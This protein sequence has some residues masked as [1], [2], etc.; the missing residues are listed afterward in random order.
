M[1]EESAPYGTPLSYADTPEE[2][3][4]CLKRVYVAAGCRTQEELAAFLGVRQSFISDAKR[5][6]MIPSQ[7]LAILLCKKWINPAW[8]LTG[9][10]PFY[11]QPADYAP[12][13]AAPG[14]SLPK[15]VP[16]EVL[17]AELVRRTLRELT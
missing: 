2:F 11:A 1:T 5:R 7:W 8:V 16:T 10:G 13:D 6:G 3:A 14:L 17:L 9:K 15:T 4:A 12:S